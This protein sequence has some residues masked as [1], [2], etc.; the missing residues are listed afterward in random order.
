MESRIIEND[1]NGEWHVFKTESEEKYYAV[2]LEKPDAMIYFGFDG[3]PY[4]S[5]NC[6]APVA[7][8]SRV[9]AFDFVRKK[10]SKLKDRL[11]ELDDE[12]GN[13]EDAKE[14]QNIYLIIEEKAD[15][16][17]VDR[18]SGSI[19]IAQDYI[20]NRR[21]QSTFASFM[22][23]PISMAGIIFPDGGISRADNKLFDHKFFGLN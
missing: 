11:I 12:S 6:P 4:L 13:I 2:Y 10:N 23:I 21:A 16:Y 5:S 7:F 9:S 22:I 15:G 19:K 8:G 18:V 17:T 14:N 3:I 1:L 20:E